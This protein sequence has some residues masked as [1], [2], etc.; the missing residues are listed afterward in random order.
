VGGYIAERSYDS[1]LAAAASIEE[2]NVDARID[3]IDKGVLKAVAQIRHQ[4]AKAENKIEIS[5]ECKR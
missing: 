2:S 1:A 3:K 5:K 4:A